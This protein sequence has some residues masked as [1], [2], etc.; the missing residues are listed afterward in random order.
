MTTPDP[1][2]GTSTFT[3]ERTQ[4]EEVSW[5]EETR[6]LKSY[7]LL[8]LDE[9]AKRQ[10]RNRLHRAYYMRLARQHGAT[11]RE[12][13]ESLGIGVPAVREY[14]IRLNEGPVG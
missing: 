10:E 4:A 13:G 11:Y 12:I 9:V 6:D 7:A 3:G 1:S 2:V 14:L 5:D 8:I